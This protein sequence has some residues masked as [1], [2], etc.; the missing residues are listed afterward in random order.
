MRYDYYTSGHKYFRKKL[1]GFEA[2]LATAD[3]NNAEER[4]QLHE[5]FDVMTH[6]LRETARYEREIVM[7]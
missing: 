4:V 2:A 5:L 6:M 3:L 1:A 7:R